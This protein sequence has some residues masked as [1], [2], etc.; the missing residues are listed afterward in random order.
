MS[1]NDEKTYDSFPLRTFLDFT[2]EEE[3]KG[4]AIALL[5][6]D[7][8]HL[9]PNGVIHGGVLFTLVDTAMGKAT[10]SVLRQGQICASIEVSIRYL[11]SVT[12]GQL[13]VRASV[14][15]A[16]QKV[17]HLESIIQKKGEEGPVAIAHGSF[18]VINT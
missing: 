13:E 14:L 16:G 5:N 3:K 12:E 9:N 2:V 10:M 1:I 4:I 15:K 8:R 11:R 7:V 18:I 17:V 6:I